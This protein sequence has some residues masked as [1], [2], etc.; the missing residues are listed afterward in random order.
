MIIGLG[1][2]MIEVDRV[3]RLRERHGERFLDRILGPLEK[4]GMHGDPDQYLASRFACKEAAMKALGTGWGRGIRW[5]DL[6]IVNLESGKPVLKFHGAAG[7]L[8][9]ELGGK[10]HVS[11]S[12]LRGHAV[13]I[14]ILEEQ[15]V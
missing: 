14:V 6:E 5:V 8:V 1:I 2:D 15:N 7:E 4:E 11:L 12:H 9:A 13:A 10:A 3:R